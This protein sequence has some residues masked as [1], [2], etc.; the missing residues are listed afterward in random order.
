MADEGKVLVIGTASADV[1]GWS[2]MPSVQGSS[3]PGIIRSGFGGVARNVAE[4]LARLEVDTVLLTAVGDDASGEQ[5]LSHAAACH[6]DISHAL[7]V[8][9]ARTGA[10]LALMDQ[11]GKLSNAVD[12]MEIMSALTSAYFR[13]HADLFGQARIAFV[14]ANLSPDAIGTVVELC[15][16]YGV[17]LCADPASATLAQK[18]LPYLDQLYMVVPNHREA[19]VLCNDSID[20]SDR[21]KAQGAA[22]QLVRLGVENAIITLSEFG[23]VYADIETVGHIPALK[24]AIVDQTGASD[25]LTAAIIFGLLEQIPLDECLRLG[26]TA[27]ALTLRTR[28][29]VRSDLSVELLY[30]ELVI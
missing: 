10:Y 1:R 9:D 18:L 15:T 29:I 23:V 21:D 16:R 12:D 27:A 26:A 25:A 20:P 5:I 6:I 17:P 14:D 30:D 2:S 7:I 13:A 3:V 8:D 4:N 22:S 24:T 11:Q 28:E 19:Q